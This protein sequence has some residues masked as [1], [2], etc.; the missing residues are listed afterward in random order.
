MTKRNWATEYENVE[1]AIRDEWK[2]IFDISPRPSVGL[3]GG[4]GSVFL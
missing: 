2:K 4:S 1:A 3:G